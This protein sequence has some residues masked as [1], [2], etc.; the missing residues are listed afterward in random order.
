MT[1]V[2]RVVATHGPVAACSSSLSYWRTAAKLLGKVLGARSP[3]A[4]NGSAKPDPVESAAGIAPRRSPVRVRL[5]PNRSPRRLQY[6]VAR[7]RGGNPVSP[8]SPLVGHSRFSRVRP[9]RV[10]RPPADDGFRL[11]A[12]AEPTCPQAVSRGSA[13][14][15]A[16]QH[17]VD[18]AL[19]DARIRG[20]GG[21]D[22][23]ASDGADACGCDDWSE[24]SDTTVP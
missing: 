21:A 17:P 24:P 20:R 3:R 11:T 9:G 8:T 15:A 5:A 12:P 18:P 13:L 2:R 1:G 19:Q 23:D 14:D 22:I 7:L 16:F 4:R 10:D 6:C